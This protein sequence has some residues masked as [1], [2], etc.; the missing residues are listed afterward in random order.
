MG[1]IEYSKIQK[2]RNIYSFTSMSLK[3]TKQVDQFGRCRDRSTFAFTTGVILSL[4]LS[5]PFGW[6]VLC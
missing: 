4:Q 6:T 3:G 5:R 1:L 2:E